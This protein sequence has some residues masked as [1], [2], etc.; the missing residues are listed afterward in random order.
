MA[1]ITKLNREISAI[2]KY[3]DV[4]ER[5]AAFGLEAKG[6]TPQ[7]FS[8]VVRQEVNLWAK[9]IKEAKIEVE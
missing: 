7:Q 6:S 8:D 3:P 4:I 2:L 9:V 5:L 1:I